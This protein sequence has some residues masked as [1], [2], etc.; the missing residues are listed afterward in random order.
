MRAITISLAFAILACLSTIAHATD[1]A[2]LKVPSI[3]FNELFNPLDNDGDASSGERFRRSML[4]DG[5]LTVHDIPGF[6]SLRRR[7]MPGVSACGATATSA[8]VTNFPDGTSRRTVAAITKGFHPSE[9]LD[10][11]Y[12]AVH[13]A[14]CSEHL[15]A[16]VDSFR[17]LVSSV[18]R[19]FVER[20]G[21]SFPSKDGSPM[22]Q[23]ADPAS[24]PFEDISS[25]AAA[26]DHLE[27][28]HAYSRG[29]RSP[30]SNNAASSE[31]ID[32]HADQGMFIMFTPGVV[33]DLSQC[34][35]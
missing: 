31:T 5:I 18:S 26:G 30:S 32:L 3:A 20:L 28:F 35:Q 4:E 25:L 6:A 2:R 27:H 11:N 7:V 21:E 12:D 8:R 17:E 22:L 10:L 15:L 23:S 9:A 13:E 14:S 34:H 19:A 29:D 16:D 1:K 24:E 33:V